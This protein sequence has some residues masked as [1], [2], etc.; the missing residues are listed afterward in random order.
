MWRAG[1]Q[2]VD[3]KDGVAGTLV[4]GFTKVNPAHSLEKLKSD[5]LPP[6]AVPHLTKND[7]YWAMQVR[8]CVCACPSVRPPPAPSP[9]TSSSSPSQRAVLPP[10]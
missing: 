7:G 4:I 6:A 2:V 3:L 8:V 5:R 9:E 10:S 1:A